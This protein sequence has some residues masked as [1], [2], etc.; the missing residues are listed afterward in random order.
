MKKR[1]FISMHY[2]EIGGAEMALVG[3]LQALDYITY[4]VDLFLHAHR[5]EMMQFIPKEVNLLPEINEYA[6]IECPMKHALLDG[7]W[8]VL[9]GRLKAKWLT[10]R[11]L[12]KK[13]VKDSAA[14]LQYVADCVSPFLPSLHQFGEY[15]LAISFLQPHNYVA[16]KVMAKKKIC[17]IHTDYTRIDINVEQELPIWNAYDHIISISP[18]VTKTF[19]QVFPSLS[20]KIIEI[21]NILSPEFVRKRSEEFQVEFNENQNENQKAAIERE[22]SQTSLS[23][24]KCEQ[25]RPKVNDD[26]DDNFPLTAKRS[27]LN[28]KYNDNH[29][30][31]DNEKPNEIKH[32]NLLSV[33]RFCEAKNYDNI[34]DICQR[35][36]MMLN[37]NEDE[38]EKFSIRWYIIGF[39]GDEQLIRQRIEEA[40]MQDHVIILGKR[41]NPYPYIKA[42]DI[43]V[44]PSRYEGKSVT[45]REAQMLCKPVVVTNY[46]TAKSQI[47]DGIDGKIVPMDNE[48]CA[49]GLAEFIMNTELQEQIK[50]YLSS[51]DYGNESEVSKI[52]LLLS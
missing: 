5:G 48:G 34:P 14:G 26:A 19:L 3:L 33:G 46:P 15:D 6:H 24:A 16:E 35:I 49:Q 20:N 30:D 4:D 38:N 22:Q 37:E 39:G 41:T 44:Q 40:G 7:C 17:W 8:G 51:H 23:S 21:E 52:E 13:G 25:A 29:N 36:N 18:D 45:V 50:E 32:V 11:Y 31:N 10:R 2:M 47:Q 42:C 28:H 9:Y 12:N 1:I 43:Y 27:P